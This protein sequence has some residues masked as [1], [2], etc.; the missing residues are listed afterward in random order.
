MRDAGLRRKL[1]GAAPAV[2]DRFSLDGFIRRWETLI[3]SL[4]PGARGSAI[5]QVR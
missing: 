5:P 2:L 3:R 1:A 4:T